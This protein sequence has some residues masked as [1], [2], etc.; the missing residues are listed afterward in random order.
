MIAMDGDA[1]SCCNLSKLVLSFS[2]LENEMS[3][4]E[5]KYLEDQIDVLIEMKEACEDESEDDYV[6][7]RIS[8]LL[9]RMIEQSEKL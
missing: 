8:Q 9:H 6:D 7:E 3:I 4:T 5:L 2:K 1:T